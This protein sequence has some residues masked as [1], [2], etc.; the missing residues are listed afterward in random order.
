ME[1]KQYEE[2][3]LEVVKFELEDIVSSGIPDTDFPDLD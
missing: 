2:P 1:V 3:Q